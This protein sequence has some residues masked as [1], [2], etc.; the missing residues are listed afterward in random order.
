MHR[1]AGLEGLCHHGV[2][3]PVRGRLPDAHRFGPGQDRGLRPHPDDIANLHI[4][5]KDGLFSA[6]QI[7]HGAVERLIQSEEIQPGRILTPFIAVV[8]IRCRGLGV[9][10]EKDDALFSGSHQIGHQTGPAGLIDFFCKHD[11]A[12]SIL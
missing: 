12:F 6:L 2:Q 9:S 1:A 3:F 7:Q 10:Q 8:L 4:V 5:C 11:Y